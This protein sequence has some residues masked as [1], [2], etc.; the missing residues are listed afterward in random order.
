MALSNAPAVKRAL[1]DAVAAATFTDPQPGVWY[2][3]PNVDHNF[4]DNIVVAPGDRPLTADQDWATIGGPAPNE[5]EGI[6][7]PGTRRSSSVKAPTSTSLRHAHGN[8]R[9]SPRPCLQPARSRTR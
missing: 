5:D 1:Y 6:D 7:I 3:D 4:H 8:S 2:S 9:P